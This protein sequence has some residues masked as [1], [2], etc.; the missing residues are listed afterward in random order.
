MELLVTLTLGAI[1]ALSLTAVLLTQLRMA[2]VSTAR[3]AVADAVRLVLHVLP[4]ELRFSSAAADLHGVGGD[5]IAGRFPRLSGAACGAAPGRLWARLEGMREPDPQKDSL[6]IIS[7]E[8]EAAFVVSDA[9]PEP[10]PCPMTGP[11]TNYR[12]DTVGSPAGTGAVL[13]FESG[14]YYLRD[15][16]FRYRLGREGRQPL[17]EEAFQDQGSHLR[18]RVD[19]AQARLDITVAPVLAAGQSPLPPFGIGLVF[20]NAAGSQ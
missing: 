5:S 3:A 15:R 1:L 4:A 14:S 11:G 20:L 7:G 9:V 17:T 10:G 8:G 2:R 6:L 13:V 16:A 12:L 19:S 18:L